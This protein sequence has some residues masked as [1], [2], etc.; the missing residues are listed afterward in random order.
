MLPYA[1]TLPTV[2]LAL[3]RLG[4]LAGQRQIDFEA[5]TR[6]DVEDAAKRTEAAQLLEDGGTDCG[7]GG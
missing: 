6:S 4:Q 2:S 3:G 1:Q 5:E 7:P